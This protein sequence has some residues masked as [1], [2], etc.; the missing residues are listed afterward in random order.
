M[1]N[2]IGALVL[3]ILDDSAER[4]IDKVTIELHSNLGEVKTYEFAS[5]DEAVSFLNT[6]ELKQV[7]I[8]SNSLAL[9]DAPPHIDGK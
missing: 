2:S 4:E 1:R 7:F 8:T 5:I 3:R 6:A 9:F